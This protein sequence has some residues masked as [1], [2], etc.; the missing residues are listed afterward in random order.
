MR[1]A[2]ATRSLRFRIT[3]V[4]TLAVAVVLLLT[5]W[6]LVG[7]QRRQL[8][9]SVDDTLEQRADDVVAALADGVPTTL[10]GTNIEDRAAQLVGLD[11]AV[12]AATPNLEGAPAVTPPP[13]GA[14]RIRSVDGLPIEDDTF[15]LL[16]RRVEVAGEPAILHVAEN[17][18]D[19]DDSVR[20]LGTSLLVAF[21]ALIVLLA[22]LTWWL[23]GHT[24]RPVEES[25]R[26][27]QRFVA[28]ASHE[29]R[30]PLTRIR[31]RLE[32]DLAHPDAHDLRATASSVLDETTGMEHLVDDLLHL[33][34]HDAG[35]IGERVSDRVD[36]DDVV[37]E[38]VQAARADNRVRFDTAK[39]S[40]AE[41]TGNR[42]EL[43]RLVRNLLENARRHATSTVRLSLG[44][45]DGS[46]ILVVADDGPGIPAERRVEV[47]ERFTRLDSARTSDQG[48]TGLGLAIARDITERHG[49]EISIS[50]TAGGGSTFTVTLP[51]T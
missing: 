16:S 40:G 19:I 8:M 51:M 3:A 15:R 29:L 22:A 6:L 41:V 10:A 18:D 47:F 34:R 9:T 26:R 49:G 31:T 11:G 42:L 32:V 43:A 23:V 4:A 12:I 25:A 46:V 50:E 30:A 20:I 45:H 28:D 37:L 36:L 24:L 33:A 21:P 2:T 5:A 17:I 44:E 13:E 48:G 35:P 1:P 38:E 14:Q 27:Q 39:V 7:T